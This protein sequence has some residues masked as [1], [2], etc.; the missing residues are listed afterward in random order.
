MELLVDRE[1]KNR[2]DERF[3]L[4]RHLTPETEGNEVKDGRK[5]PQNLSD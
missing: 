2:G 3:A 4:K 1:V 5:Y